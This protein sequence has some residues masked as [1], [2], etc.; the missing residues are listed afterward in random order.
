MLFACIHFVGLR[1]YTPVVQTCVIAGIIGG[2]GAT[3]VQGA[4]G[5]INI[6]LIKFFQNV[7]KC[8][9]AAVCTQVN[10]SCIQFYNTSFNGCGNKQGSQNY[11]DA[12]LPRSPPSLV[13]KVVFGNLLPKPNL[14]TK[15]G[16][17][18]LTINCGN[19]QGSQNFWDFPSSLPTLVPKLFWHLLFVPSFV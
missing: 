6:G 16:V 18:A 17:V 19:K 3:G 11:W 9:K 8:K 7:N 2:A 14:C 4:A 15:F 12:P 5:I 1:I 13:L 10:G